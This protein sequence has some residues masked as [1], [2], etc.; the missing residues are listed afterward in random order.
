MT[1]PEP[2]TSEVLLALRDGAARVVLR[3]HESEPVPLLTCSARIATPVREWE[4]VR[5]DAS[6]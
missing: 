2:G 6:P 1:R 5:L 3:E 4:L